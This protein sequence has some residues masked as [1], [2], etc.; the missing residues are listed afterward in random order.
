MQAVFCNNL[1]RHHDSN[2]IT[3]TTYVQL[4]R[5]FH[6]N[7]PV[8]RLRANTI[9]DATAATWDDTLRQAVAHLTATPNDE[10]ATRLIHLPLAMGGLGLYDMTQ[11]RHALYLSAWAQAAKH[12]HRTLDLTTEQQ[13]DTLPPAL[14]EALRRTTHSL[15]ALI[16]DFEPPLGPSSSPAPT[17]RPPR[18][19]TI[20]STSATSNMSSLPPTTHSRPTSAP[21]PHQARPH[22]S[23]RR[24]SPRPP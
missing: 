15:R 5:N 21:R 16:P 3:S 11:R 23:T 8:H 6:N 17:S 19:C 1:R 12:F 18:N 22:G 20:A 9:D 7:V 10:T 13:V 14:H 4:L 2:R 24:P